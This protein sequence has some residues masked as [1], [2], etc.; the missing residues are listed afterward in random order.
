METAGRRLET[1]VGRGAAAA[2]GF[3]ARRLAEVGRAGVRASGGVRRL[4]GAAAVRARPG[5]HI[6]TLLIFKLGFS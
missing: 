6:E 5:S 3:A 1:R 2:Q 4:A